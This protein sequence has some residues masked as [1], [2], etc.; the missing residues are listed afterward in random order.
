MVQASCLVSPQTKR[1]KALDSILCP[2]A[3]KV[4]KKVPNL[5]LPPDSY[6]LLSVKYINDLVAEFPLSA[7]TL[8]SSLAALH[9]APTKQMEPCLETPADSQQ[10]VASTAVTN[11]APAS[12]AA[13]KPAA[14]A[15]PPADT[16]M[17]HVNTAVPPATEDSNAPGIPLDSSA[18]V[19][20][21]FF[22]MTSTS[23]ADFVVWPHPTPAAWRDIQTVALRAFVT[24]EWLGNP[25]VQARLDQQEQGPKSRVYQ[26]SRQALIVLVHQLLVG[27]VMDPHLDMRQ[28]VRSV[29]IQLTPSCLKS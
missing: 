23:R 29:F 1:C 4:Y 11:E 2:V 19:T 12:A 24:L 22:D 3:A 7:H 27:H 18:P 16:A 15:A 17:S 8:G 21:S 25:D 9:N 28:V 13:G 6:H 20:H 10:S 5:L 14:T 26:A